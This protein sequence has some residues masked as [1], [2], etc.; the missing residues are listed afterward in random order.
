MR[1]SRPSAL[2]APTLLFA[3]VATAAL[4]QDTSR[5]AVQSQG[6]AA[7]DRLQ[8]A[9]TRAKERAADG[10]NP[11]TPP[12]PAEETRRRA[13]QA[14]RARTHPPEIEERARAVLA[15]GEAKMAADREAMA[16]RLRQSLGL[17]TRET[18]ATVKAAAPSPKAW[19]PVL[20]VS[21]SIPVPVLRAYAAQVERVHGVLAFRGM[22]GGLRKVGPMAKLTA[23]IL[24]LDAGCEGPSCAMRNVQVIIDPI[25]FRQHNIARVPA[26]AMVPGDPT[27]PYCERDDDSPRARFTVYGDSALPGLLDEYARLG[28]KEEVRNAQALLGTR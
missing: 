6:E 15:A 16:K 18:D 20:F 10:P 21:S 1:I 4:A 9:M 3:L 11:N 13:F 27:E 2:R 24:R 7:M 23:E 14:L 22:P 8:G 28:G 26:L 5:Q 19:M 25:V 12:P 17:D